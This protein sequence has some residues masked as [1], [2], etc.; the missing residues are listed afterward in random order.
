MKFLLNLFN[1]C[2]SFC[3]VPKDWKN[4]INFL[5]FEKGEKESIRNP[6]LISLL[7]TLYKI[8]MKVFINLLQKQLDA[9]QL[10]KQAG[11][12]NVF[13]TIDHIYAIREINERSNEFELPLCVAFVDYVKA[14]NSATSLAVMYAIKISNIDSE[15]AL[16]ETFIEAAA[17][18]NLHKTSDTFSIRNCVSQVNTI[19][20][21]LFNAVLQINLE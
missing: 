4:V 10:K 8:L 6:R 2:I 1:K 7:S 20:P 12:C 11:F 13:S 18:L 3:D 19:S 5:L 16:L 14:F 21:K 17:K 9:I 15:F